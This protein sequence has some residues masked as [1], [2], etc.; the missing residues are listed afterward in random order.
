MFGT[1]ADRLYRRPDIILS[2]DQI[3]SRFSELAGI[4]SPAVVGPFRCAVDTILDCLAP[5]DIAVTLD[6]GMRTAPLVRLFREQC[7]VAATEDNPCPL[8]S[9]TLP[10]LV[11][12]QSVAGVET[13]TDHVAL[14]E[15]VGVE[16]LEGLVA[17][18][19][20]A[21]LGRCGCRE[22][23]HPARR[24]ETGPKRKVTRIDDMY[25]HEISLSTVP[26]AT[27]FAELE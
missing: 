23:K 1:S 10:K 24:D 9:C 25:A 14:L 11:A 20:I 15:L 12:D 26:V 21:P 6:H 17:E 3:P 7:G 8:R 22:H 27:V 5:S 18:Y 19:G 2:L 13:D 4:N 16:L